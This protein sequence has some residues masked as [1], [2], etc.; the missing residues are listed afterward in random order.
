M[1]HPV[2]PQDIDD[3]AIGLRGHVVETPCPPSQTL[4]AITGASVY[5][6]F[7]NLQYTAAFK[8][9]GA[10]WFLEGMSDAERARGVVAASA[11]NHAQGLAHHAQLLDITATIVMPLATPFT[12]IV[13]TE[14]SGATVVLHGA[15]FEAARNYA[16]ELAATSGATFVPAFD[17]RA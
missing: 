15:D 14:L 11:G 7:E 13:R 4:S 17:D 3:A 6:K 5:C 12:K 9:R 16:L 10:R 8:E 1:T 2:T